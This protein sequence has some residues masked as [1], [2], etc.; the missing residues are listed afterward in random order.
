MEKTTVENESQPKL[1]KRRQEPVLRTSSENP[2]FL[3]K[4]EVESKVRSWTRMRG[5]RTKRA[6][7]VP[8]ACVCWWW[9][10]WYRMETEENS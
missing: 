4:E 5:K 8:T 2:E 10:N 3:L 6:V 1:L 9:G 7:W